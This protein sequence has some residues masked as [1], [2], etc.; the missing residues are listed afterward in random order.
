[1]IDIPSNLLP[2]W[3]PKAEQIGEDIN[4]EIAC[5]FDSFMEAF[6]HTALSKL[7]PSI[8]RNLIRAFPADHRPPEKRP[9]VEFVNACIS[10]NAFN[11]LPVIRPN[12]GLFFHENGCASAQGT[13]RVKGDD[14]LLGVHSYRLHFNI[15]L[16]RYHDDIIMASLSLSH[17]AIM[18]E[19]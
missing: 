7:P 5:K 4:T 11:M 15:T 19:S 10:R 2:S 3:P 16:W 13:R 9:P 18:M 8:L 1:M 14:H 12:R 6:W 17:G